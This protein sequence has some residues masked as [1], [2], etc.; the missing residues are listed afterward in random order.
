MTIAQVTDHADQGV[1]LLLDQYKEKPRL[2]AWIRSFLDEVQEAEDMLVA[3]ALSRDVDTAEAAQLEL[4]GRVV[5]QERVGDTD[6]VF[7]LFIKVRIRINRSHGKAVDI[8]EVGRLAT[9]GRTSKFY[10][11]YPASYVLDVIEPLDATLAPL[12]A[13]I[14]SLLAE[15]TA[16]GVESSLHWSDDPEDETFAFATGDEEELDEDRGFA[17]DDGTTGGKLIGAF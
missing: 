10:P 15:A 11:L 4:L 16:A 6:D 9:D 7:R 12:A 1:A 17:D 14:A 5:G 13:Y 3:V 8:I 2:E